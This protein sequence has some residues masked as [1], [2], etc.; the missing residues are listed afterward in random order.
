VLDG[1]PAP[2]PAELVD[3][4]SRGG[5]RLNSILLLDVPEEELVRR[6]LAR[7][8]QESRSDDTAGAVKTR[9]Q[10]Y[11]RDTARSSLIRATRHCAP[12]AGNR[13]RDQIA[14]EIQRVIGRYHHQVA[15]RD[16]DHGAAGDR[17]GNAGAVARQVR[18]C[19][20]GS[21]A[22]PRDLAL[23]ALPRAPAHLR[24]G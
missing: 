19:V 2:P 21:R 11:Q 16:R 5:H 18:P 15:A 20:T 17:G 7:A 10:V 22:A 23:C 6:L 8:T 13:R 4:T 3:R 12:R 14:T 1:F 24:G 9:L